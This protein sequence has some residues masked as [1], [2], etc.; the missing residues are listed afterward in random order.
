MFATARSGT[1]RRTSSNGGSSVSAVTERPRARAGTMP[2]AA[3]FGARWDNSLA[4]RDLAWFPVADRAPLRGR[5]NRTDGQVVVPMSFLPDVSLYYF[6]GDF[7]E[8]LDRFERGEP[9]SYRTHDEVAALIF[10][11]V[12]RGK[13]VRVTSFVTPVHR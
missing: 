4:K 12:E 8:V 2:T 6:A 10:D 5:A 3:Q 11:L 9:Q 1:S 7:C 13:R